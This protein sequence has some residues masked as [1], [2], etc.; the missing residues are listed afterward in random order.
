MTG[1]FWAILPPVIAII[2]ALVTKE[3]YLSLMIGIASGALMYHDFHLIKA[4]DT[5][6]AIM[7]EKIGANCDILIF[8]VLLG[9]LVAL[10]HK[11]WCFQSL[12]KVGSESNPYK[13]TGVVCNHL[14]WRCNFR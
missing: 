5:I 14:S 12:W 11:I 6:F 8:L 10:D 7:G 3:V 1:T 9:I 4:M 2:L 13:E